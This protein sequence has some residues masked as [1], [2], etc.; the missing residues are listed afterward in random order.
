MVGSS[1][2]KQIM[3]IT[4]VYYH[5]AQL[6]QLVDDDGIP[7]TSPRRILDCIDFSIPLKRESIQFHFIH[8]SNPQVNNF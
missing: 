2:N 5:C 7:I 3:I 6:I 4:P 8:F 1:C